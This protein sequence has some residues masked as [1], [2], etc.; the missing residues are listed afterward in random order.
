L[1][2]PFADLTKIVRLLKFDPRSPPLGFGNDP[3]WAERQEE[4]RKSDR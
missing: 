2:D 4:R 1:S 3:A